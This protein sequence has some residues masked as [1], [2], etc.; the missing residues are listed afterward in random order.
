MALAKKVAKPAKK[1]APAKAAAQAT[2]TLKHLATA[3][4][5]SH[6]IAKKQAE[7]V[8]HDLVTLTAALGKRWAVL[9]SGQPCSTSRHTAKAARTVST[10]IETATAPASRKAG[11]PVA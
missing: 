5:D 6:D 2:V 3:L 7:A 1:A 11:Q 9:A 4:A 8:L 10:A